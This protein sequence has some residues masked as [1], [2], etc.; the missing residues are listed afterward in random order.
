MMFKT[1]FKYKTHNLF[2]CL[3]LYGNLFTLLLQLEPR[4]PTVGYHYKFLVDLKILRP[5]WSFYFIKS[6]PVG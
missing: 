2:Y 1:G 3:T 6:K 5:K 4:S